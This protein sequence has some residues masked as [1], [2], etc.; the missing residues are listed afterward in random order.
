MEKLLPSL[1][2]GN[3]RLLIVDYDAAMSAETLSEIMSR[4]RQMSLPV[5]LMSCKAGKSV[6]SYIS[7]DVLAD[8]LSGSSRLTLFRSQPVSSYGNRRDLR[9]VAET[10]ATLNHE[11]NNSLM[12]ITANVEILLREN[13]RLP[14]DFAEKVRL[15]GTAANWIK[16]SVERLTC[17]DTLR[18]RETPAGRMISIEDSLEPGSAKLEKITAK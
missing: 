13:K 9:I 5:L 10:A 8:I 17:L 16:N 6:I 2:R 18:Y 14:G 15:I 1:Y 4:S 3:I 7:E 12:A 11:I